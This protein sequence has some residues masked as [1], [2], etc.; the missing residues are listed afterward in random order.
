MLPQRGIL[1]AARRFWGG[2]SFGLHLTARMICC[3]RERIRKLGRNRFAGLSSAACNQRKTEVKQLAALRQSPAAAA[4]SKLAR[5]P[6]AT[7][8]LLASGWRTHGPTLL[9]TFATVNGTPLGGL[10]RNGCFLP[11]L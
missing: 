8:L 2:A 9:K 11:T 3:G 7:P 5:I 6:A 1:S 10:E 4:L